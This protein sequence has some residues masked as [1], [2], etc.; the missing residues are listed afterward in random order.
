MSEENKK[1]MESAK[2]EMQEQSRRMEELNN[3]LQEAEKRFEEIKEKIHQVEEIAGP[4]KV[5]ITPYCIFC[6]LCVATGMRLNGGRRKECL[7]L[8][9]LRAAYEHRSRAFPPNYVKK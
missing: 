1:K 3:I 7:F 9:Q 8:I 2:K 4:I 5:P 6:S